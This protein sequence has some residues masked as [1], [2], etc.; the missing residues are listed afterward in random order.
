MFTK[1]Q[2]E[3]ARACRNVDEILTLGGENAIELTKEQAEQLFA[4]LNKTVELSDE[5]LEA[6]SGGAL[7]G[8]N[9][10]ACRCDYCRRLVKGEIT[11]DIIICAYCGH[12]FSYRE[13]MGK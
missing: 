6:A 10:N 7:M 1:E 12:V 4:L 5:E 9:P 13:V 2:L 3:K 11:S 8:K